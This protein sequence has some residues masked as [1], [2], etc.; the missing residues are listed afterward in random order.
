MSSYAVE[1]SAYDIA[2]ASTTTL[3]YTSGTGFNTESTDTP[4]NTHFAPRLLE[5]LDISRSMFSRGRTTGRAKVGLGKIVLANGDGG[6]DALLGYAFDGRDIVVRHGTEG[7]AYPSAWTLA[8]KGTMRALE[9]PDSEELEI[10]LRDRQHVVEVPLQETLYAGDNTLPA[11]LEGVEDL[12]GKPK[13]L[14]FG[15]ARNFAPPVVNTTKLIYQLH[16]GLVDS[17]DGVFDRG[18]SLARS[19][20]SWTSETS[21]TANDLNDVATEGSGT[22]VA[23]GDSGTIIRSTD[24]GANWSAATTPSFSTDDVHT[25]VYSEALSLFIAGGASGKVAW[26]DDDGDTW[27]QVTGGSNPFGGTE[28][29]QASAASPSEVILGGNAGVLARATDGKSYTAQSNNLSKV[30]GLDHGNNRFVA[31]GESAAI[32]TST[33]GTSWSAADLG[34]ATGHNDVARGRN[35]WATAMAKTDTV[36]RSGDGDVWAL[37]SFVGLDQI[38]HK[39]VSY[40]GPAGEFVAAGSGPSGGSISTSPDT[41][42]WK[43]VLST[44]NQLNG[45]AVTADAAIAVGAS[46]TILTMDPAGTYASQADLLDDDLQPEPG[47]Y[48]AFLD[49]GG[50]YIRLGS[51]PDGQ[52]TVDATEGAAAADRTAAQ[53]WKDVLGQAGQT[54][55][56][57][58]QKEDDLTAWGTS[59]TPVVTSGVSDPWGGTDAYTVEDNDSG[60]VEWIEEP[61]GFTGDGQKCAVWAVRENTTPASGHFMVIYDNTAGTYRLRVTIS[62]WTN[63][64]PD[65]NAVNGSVLKKE[66]IGNG[67]WAVYCQSTSITAANDNQIWVRPASTSPQT[68]KI[69]VYRVWAFDDSDVTDEANF[70]P[71]IARLDADNDAVLG[72]WAGTDEVIAADALTEMAQSVGAWW[73]LDRNGEFRIQRFEDPNGKTTEHSFDQTNI[74]GAPQRLEEN[75]GG[76]PAWRVVVRYDRNY[77]VQGSDIAA[78]VTDA[79]RALISKRW[80][81]ESD[82]DATVKTAHLLAVEEIIETLLTASADASAEATR[83]LALRDSAHHAWRFPAPLDADTEALDLGS[84]VGLSYKEDGSGRLGLGTEDEFVVIGIDADAGPEEITFT[85]W[86]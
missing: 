83:L 33:D 65:L 49:S 9:A 10:R 50:S 18:I 74:Y 86:G 70:W 38:E 56:D 42:L 71:D 41:S 60:G 24:D 58:I 59:G 46:G 14:L 44:G 20:F 30:A 39:A 28:I 73:G 80:K 16:D 77:T 25:V 62:G 51:P 21:G 43:V 68:G 66:E 1:I 7:D 17:V 84:I 35:I 32:D 29:V 19:P 54:V 45:I 63:G 11:G 82:E 75:G 36:G 4:T 72:Y 26:S 48:K 2:G 15:K 3:Y 5:P 13:P 23:V 85:V 64:E 69:D 52:I 57:N 40:G 67:Y 78:G 12:K 79:R 76:T 81:E 6:L 27:T 47:T 53:L 22:W 55:Y 37:G 8:W 31:V 34:Y 61:P